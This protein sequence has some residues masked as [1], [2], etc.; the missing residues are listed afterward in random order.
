MDENYIRNLEV[1]YDSMVDKTITLENEKEQA[2]Q[3]P[4]VGVVYYLGYSI[5]LHEFTPYPCMDVTMTLN[6]FT[7]D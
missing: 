3:R 4:A 2:V 1:A 6:S 7:P 5:P